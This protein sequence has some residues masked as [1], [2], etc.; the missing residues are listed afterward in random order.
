MTLTPDMLPRTREVSPRVQIVASSGS[1]NF[2]LAGEL[3]A[4]ASAWP[5]LAMLLTDNQTAG[6][7]RRGRTFSTP[8]G[9]AVATSVVI[10]VTQIPPEA[11]GWLSLFAGAALVDAISA[12]LGDSVGRITMK[13]PNDVQVDGRKISGI[14][15]E[16]VGSDRVIVGTGVNTAMTREQLPV[17]TATSFA[18]LGADV[19]LDAL[20][21]DYVTGLG[22]RADR[23]SASHGNA[24]AAGL[25][26]ELEA[27]CATVGTDVR[28]HLS[29]G[30]LV[31]V[32]SSLGAA[33]ELIVRTAR[34]DVPV[35]AGDVVHLR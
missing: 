10:D 25:R 21:A 26:T 8:P 20:L 15:S 31:G 17:P 19:D 24:E 14:L 27:S 3:A 18:V 4:D 30:D 22:S 1:T 33:G 2:E 34:G 23:L 28:V 35:T 13:W 11:R 12:Q 9:S 32:A 29:D 5:H 7:G 6:R 16:A